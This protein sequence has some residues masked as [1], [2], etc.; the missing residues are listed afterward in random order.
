MTPIPIPVFGYTFSVGSSSVMPHISFQLNNEFEDDFAHIYDFL[1]ILIDFSPVFQI[2]ANTIPINVPSTTS[3][4]RYC[5]NCYQ[6]IMVD[7]SVDDEEN[8]MLEGVQA[9]SQ[10]F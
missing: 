6:T 4:D 3:I 9:L 10:R 5:P 8:P 1:G 7:P 2:D